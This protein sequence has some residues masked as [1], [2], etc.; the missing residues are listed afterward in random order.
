MWRCD[1]KHGQKQIHRIQHL[2]AKKSMDS[3]K[4][5]LVKEKEFKSYAYVFLQGG[6]M[7][8]WS[9]PLNMTRVFMK[10]TWRRVSPCWRWQFLYGSIKKK[11]MNWSVVLSLQALSSYMIMIR[12]KWEDYENICYMRPSMRFLQVSPCGT[13]N[14]TSWNIQFFVRCTEKKTVIPLRM[15][16]G[17]AMPD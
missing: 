8:W 14:S 15:L 2:T 17:E 11:I 6:S 10:S 12:I 16:K 13:R 1:Y 3:C 7:G 4:S 5:S 9:I